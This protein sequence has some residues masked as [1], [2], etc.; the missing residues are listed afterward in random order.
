MGQLNRA[1][2]IVIMA[3]GILALTLAC[4]VGKKKASDLNIAF[5]QDTLTVGYTYWW[6]ESGPFIGSCGEEL[7]LV[8]TGIVSALKAPTDAAGPLYISR[9][10]IITIENVFKIK[11]LGAQRYKGQKYFLSDCFNDLDL[12]VGDTVLVV[13]YDYE[14]A[15]S[16]PGN[17]SILKIDDFDD[18]LIKSLKTYIDM[19]QN[20]LKLI[21]DRGLWA[22]HGLGR[23][24]EELIKCK[25]E[26]RA[27]E[28]SGEPIQ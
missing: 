24:L 2:T 7:S 5:T 11:D 20:P 18:P 27:I 8:F 6:P 12:D 3:F 17:N 19:G 14:G 9:E 28:N 1:V 4:D 16:I 15:Y 25:E 23:K 22:T 21:D 10:G 13:C 26:M